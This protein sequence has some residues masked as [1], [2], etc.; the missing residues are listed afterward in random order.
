MHP[1]ALVLATLA[2]AAAPV[3]GA[4]SDPAGD[5]AGGPG[6]DIVRAA[7]TFDPEAGSLSVSVTFTAAP[8]E[9]DWGIVNASVRDT[10][11]AGCSGAEFGRLRGNGRTTA[12]S[13]SAGTAADGPQPDGSTG[14]STAAATNTKSDDGRTTTLQTSHPRLAGRSAGCVAIAISHQGALDELSIPAGSTETGGAPGGTGGGTDDTVGTPTSPRDVRLA[15][16]RD[17]RFSGRTAHVRLAGVAEGMTGRLYLTLPD[18]RVIATGRYAATSSRTIS[19]RL[20]ATPKGRKWLRTH[21]HGRASLGIVST[22]RTTVERRYTMRMR[23]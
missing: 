21:P 20:T 3:G 4:L 9:A 23:R 22:L 7:W 6:T 1:A 5:S 17:L 10:S 12:A 19:V 11:R 14:P 16:S 15:S 13:A 18:T 2:L 8:T